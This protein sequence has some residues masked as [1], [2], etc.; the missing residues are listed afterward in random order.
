MALRLFFV[1][2]FIVLTGCLPENGAG[3]ASNVRRM[4]YGLTLKPT[5]IDPHIHQSS[6]LGIPLRQVYDT[7]VYREPVGHAIVAGLATDWSI[8]EDGLVYSFKLR[9][10]VTFHDGTPFNAQAVAANLDRITNP[11]TASQRAVF[12]LGP[13]KGY[14][15]VD[16]YTIDILLNEPYSPLLDSLAQVYL[17]IAS[18]TALSE[19]SDNRY[20][21]HQ[22]GTGPFI[23]EEYVP[24]ERLVIRRN[25]DY[26]WGPSFYEA[27]DENSVNEIEFRFFDDPPTRSLALESDEAQVMGELLPTDARL[28]TGNSSIQINPVNVPG[29]PLQFLINTQQFPTD[30]RAVRQALLFGTNRN[31]IVDAVFQRFSPVAWGPLTSSTLYYD[32]S[33]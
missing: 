28:L 30:E 22:V 5:G 23:F 27:P 17:A 29:L 32:R 15:I 19:Y 13:Y 16:D 25:P 3:Q 21:F 11:E 33:V 24:H 18:P 14:E 20:Q 8:S 26:K 7:L 2:V 12:M 9:T 1:L 31:A 10:D 4:V 6:E